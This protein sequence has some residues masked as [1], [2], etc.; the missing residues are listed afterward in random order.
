MREK[1]FTTDG[2]GDRKGRTIAYTDWGADDNP[3]VLVCVHGLTRNSRDFDALAEA[4]AP[5]MRVVCPDVA[6]RGGSDWLAAAEEYSYAQYLADTA[7]LLAEIGA[8]QVDWIGTSM[9]GF[10]GMMLASAKETPIKRLIVNDIGP[11]LPKAALERIAGYLSSGQTFADLDGLETYLRTVHAPFGALTDAQWRHMAETSAR[12]VEGGITFHY[13]PQIADAFKQVTG[14]D[15]DVWEIWDKIA[16]P[17]LTIRGVD[18]DVL[19]KD[20]ADE[21]T[22]RGP[23]AELHEI[24]GCGHAPALMDTDQIGLVRHWLAKG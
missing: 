5:D 7:A 13:D 18:S 6:G 1:T 20:T 16:C 15:I 2:P 10:L 9:G 23:R 12:P 8:A 24:T 22:R 3:R 4:L 17:V 14:A 11:Y 19:P 21:M